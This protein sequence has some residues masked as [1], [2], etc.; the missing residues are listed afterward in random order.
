M[1]SRV[2]R[3]LAPLLLLAGILLLGNGCFQVDSILKVG[4]DGSGTFQLTLGMTEPAI[5]RT[6]RIVDITRQLAQSGGTVKTQKTFFV[7]QLFFVFHPDT[8]RERLAGMTPSTLTLKKVSTETRR[9]W[10][11]I[12]IE[13]GFRDIKDLGQWPLL[14][15]LGMSYKR[16]DNGRRGMLSIEMPTLDRFG[17]LPSMDNPRT[18]ENLTPILTGLLIKFRAQFASRILE[19]NG[20]TTAGQTAF[21]EFDFDRNPDT[22][23]T[24]NRTPLYVVLENPPTTWTEFSRPAINQ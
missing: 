2:I 13:T 9:E 12:K 21:W 4:K 11:I 19:S 6:Q 17:D 18:R 8:I 23:D 10:R 1:N 24:L 3:S 14:Y 20:S 16:I 15:R 7:E 22:L 5:N